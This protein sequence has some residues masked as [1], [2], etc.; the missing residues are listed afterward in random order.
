MWKVRRKKRLHTIP[1]HDD[2]SL[3]PHL[4]LSPV[5]LRISRTRNHL[6]F[7]IFFLMFLFT[8]ETETEHEQGRGRER[9]RPRIQ[10]RLQAPSCRH[11][12]RRGAGTHEPRDHDLSR[13]QML[14]RLSPPGAPL[15]S[16][17]ACPPNQNVS[18]VGSGCLL[19]HR[20]STG[21]IGGRKCALNR[22]SPAP[23]WAES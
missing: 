19:L 23:L 22:E 1:P 5:G 10:S 14:N 3:A 7:L 15:V 21:Q 12:A 13:S 6:F 4:P 11:R 17:T 8:F 20:N 2:R 18:S 16:F 9:G